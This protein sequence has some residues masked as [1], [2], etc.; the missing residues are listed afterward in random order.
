MSDTVYLGYDQEQLDA[1]LNL[2]ARWP[3]HAEYFERWATESAAFR[4]ATPGRLDL[5][6]GPTPGQTLDLF[7]V[8][9]APYPLVAFVHGGYWQ[10]LDKS[11]FSYLA[12]RFL[13][14]GIGYAS[15]NYDLAPGARIGEMVD[16]VR[17]A[18]VWLQAEADGLGIDP[19]R[20]VAA[21]HSAGGHLVTMAVATD[22]AADFGLAAAPVSA[23]CSISGVYDLEPL[24]LCYQQPVLQ[25]DAATLEAMSPLRQAPLAPVP[26]VCAVGA[27]E[28]DEFLRQQAALAESWRSQG[29]AVEELVI[30]AEN[31]FSIL[32]LLLDAQDPL[33]ARVLSLA[34]A[35][36]GSAP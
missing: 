33:T 36:G 9:E 6:Y 31:H 30:A 7:P 24:S 12:P 3:E 5:P 10:S 29:A 13:E 18:L 28:T 19:G 21:G 15:L 1:Q 17:R 8:A 14:R 20:I 4:A 11:D 35:A 27:E 25:I 34:G 26:L 2:R 32:D 23:V 16:Q 22:W